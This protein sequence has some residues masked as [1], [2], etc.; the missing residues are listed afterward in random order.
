MN[1]IFS[2]TINTA[3]D[4]TKKKTKDPALLLHF[5]DFLSVLE[6]TETRLYFDRSIFFLHV[7]HLLFGVVAPELRLDLQGGLLLLGI[8]GVRAGALER[9]IVVETVL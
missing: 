6:T 8:P 1:Y 9:V 3:Q 7:L 4:L 2:L 5:K